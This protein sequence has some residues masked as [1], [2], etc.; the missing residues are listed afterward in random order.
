MATLNSTENALVAV[1]QPCGI[2]VIGC[3]RIAPLH[4]KAIVRN[5]DFMRLIAVADPDAGLAAQFAAEFGAQHALTSL[6]EAL[7][8]DTV[9][10]VILCTPNALHAMQAQQGLSAGRHVLVEKPFAETVEDAERIAALADRTGLVLAAGHTFRHVEAVRT[11]QD[12]RAEF[13]RLRAVSISMCVFWDGP[14]APWWATRSADEGLVLSLFAPHAIDF[15]QLV[16][17]EV[18]PVRIQVE[19]ARHQP[20]WQAEDEAMILLRYPDDVLASIHVSY[21]QRRMM[22]RKVAH[23]EKATVRIENGEELWIDDEPVVM[24]ARPEAGDT[25]LFNDGITHYF[26][27]QVREFALAVRGQPH[28]SVLHPSALRQT[29]LNRA[30]VAAARRE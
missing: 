23:F 19:A 3:G 11:L 21:N 4:L 6:D 13:G 20:G 30:I 24:P 26:E 10:A 7:A 1:D 15:L 22:N 18:D 14:Q 5:P 28:R 9:D 17:G 25:A 12:R 29:R 27:M 2:A 8:L 16:V